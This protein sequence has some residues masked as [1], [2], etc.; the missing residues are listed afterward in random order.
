ME[1]VIEDYYLNDKHQFEAKMEIILKLNAL[2]YG[3]KYIEFFRNEKMCISFS[4]ILRLLSI[5]GTQEDA[6][7]SLKMFLDNFSITDIES[8]I[9]SIFTKIWEYLVLTGIGDIDPFQGGIEA[10][11]L[12][13]GREIKTKLFPMMLQIPNLLQCYAGFMKN[14]D[15]PIH[16]LEGAIV[17]FKWD[18]GTEMQLP[19]TKIEQIEMRSEDFKIIILETIKIEQIISIEGETVKFD[20]TEDE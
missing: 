17:K 14:I 7:Q 1:E 16:L 13:K 15:F 3:I 6:K 10:T 11:L 18:D 4:G 2:N 19:V 12:V 20:E 9:S 5:N 8:E